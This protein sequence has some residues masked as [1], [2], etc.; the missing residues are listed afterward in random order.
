VNPGIES[1]FVN[2]G[3]YR[4]T[5]ALDM[6]LHCFPEAACLPAGLGNTTCRDDYL[7]VLKNTSVLEKVQSMFT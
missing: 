6:V 3:W 2:D 1:P 5:D 7:G 4:S